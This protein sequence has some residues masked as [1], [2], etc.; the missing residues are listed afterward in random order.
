MKNLNRRSFFVTLA[1]AST[2]QAASER[3]PLKWKAVTGIE[4]N[5]VV[6]GKIDG[7]VRLFVT[8]RMHYRNPPP[9]AGYLVSLDAAGQILYKDRAH[10]G[11]ICVFPSFLE[12]KGVGPSVF[13]ACGPY[14]PDSVGE[15]RLVNAYD[16]RTRWTQPTS[17][18]FFG[19]GSCVLADV[20]GD[21]EEELVYGDQ[22]AVRC[23]R[24][25]DGKLKW[26]YNDR[27]TICHGRL[28]YGEINQDSR[29]ELVFGTEY[30]NADKSSSM[31]A[32]N[33]RGNVLWRKDGIAGDMGSTPAVL[34]DVDGDGH[35]EILK[36]EL[37][38]LGREKMPYAG[39]F[40]YRGDGT[41]KYRADFGVSGMAVGDL[42]G[43]G[44]PEAV[45][46][47]DGRDGGVN[48][49][50]EIRCLDLRTGKMKWTTPVPRA[51]LGSQDPVMADLTGD[52][53]LNILVS[54]SNP[55][56]YGR[57]KG[58]EPYGDIYIVDGRGKIVWNTTL[59]DFVHQPFVSDIDG[60]GRNEIVLACHDG[61]IYCYGTPGKAGRLWSVTGGSFERTYGAE[62]L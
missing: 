61:T 31:V 46:I 49:R 55:S 36:V 53:R 42:D 21:G 25:R 45:G 9:L 23:F 59:P 54:S 12:P 43:D 26:L 24:A 4:N 2:G 51:W 22:A 34:A 29:P 6:A 3:Y 41:L 39:L 60:D 58:E 13:Y 7:K 38:L 35:L 20:D 32:I 15:A 50:N 40:C 18:Q 16:G 10:S 30:S 56:G 17:N 44:F 47:S 33:G 27:V 28:A 37:D 5:G 1:A 11:G 8:G 57:R 19:N 52:G 14:Q 48:G 62:P